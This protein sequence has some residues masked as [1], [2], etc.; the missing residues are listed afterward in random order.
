MHILVETETVPLRNSVPIRHV[1]HAFDEDGIPHD[2]GTSMAMDIL[3]EDL[4][5]W[6]TILKSARAA[7]EVPPGQLR[8]ARQLGHILK[9]KVETG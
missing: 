4:H 3:L 8:F 1:V 7:G 6:A 5:W 9:P 2:K